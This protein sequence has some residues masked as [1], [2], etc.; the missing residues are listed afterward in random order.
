MPRSR[1]PTLLTKHD[2][3]HLG[4][5][6]KLNHFK[7]LCEITNQL[8]INCS[9]DTAWNALREHSINSYTAVKKPNITLANIQKCKNWCQNI[10]NWSDDEWRKV[11]WSNES[12]V[13]LNLLLCKIKVWHMKGERYQVDCLA[14]NKRSGRISVMFW[15]CFWQN[16]LGP[17]VAFPK[18]KVNSAK[19]CEILEEHLFPFYMAV[20]E[21]TGEEPWFMDD[22][23]KVHKSAETMIFKDELGVRVLEWPSQSPDL[24]PIENLWKLWKDLIQKTNPFPTNREELI[25]AAQAAWEELKMTDIGQALADSIRNSIAAVKAAKG[26]P[27]KY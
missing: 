17:L 13:E 9:L 23:T 24:N 6:T 27:T 16:E 10:G 22:N 20:K 7:S 4:R 8:L 19:Y 14:P 3:T 25:A 21:T 12:T 2:K 1:H 11:I 15:S 26:H 18:G 5:I